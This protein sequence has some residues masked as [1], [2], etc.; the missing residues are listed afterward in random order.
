MIFPKPLYK[1][2][3]KEVCRAHLYPV[4]MPN[5]DVI[6]PLISV[7]KIQGILNKPL[8][9]PWAKK[10][11]IERAREELVKALTSGMQIDLNSINSILDLAKKEPDKKKDEAADIGT[12]THEAIDKWISGEMPVLTDDIKPG[13]N[14]FQH[15]LETE[16]IRIIKGDTNLASIK[17]MFGGRSDG[18]GEKDGKI[19]LID[20]KTGKNLYDDTIIQIGGYDIA[21][22]ETY[23]LQVDRAIVLRIGK[24]IPGDIEPKEANLSAGREAFMSAL[25]LFKRMNEKD[26]LWV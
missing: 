4:T 13:F 11:A 6:G 17:Y 1:V 12:R 25:S 19:I 2:G 20:F 16:K 10:V 22:L 7:T 26:T 23:G 21:T 3:F 15:W 5:G 18:Y 9:V 14:N 24:E 8:L